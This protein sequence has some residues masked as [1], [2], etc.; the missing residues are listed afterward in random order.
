MELLQKMAT[1]IRAEIDQNGSTA[2][3]FICTENSR[4]SHISQLWAAVMAHHFNLP[5]KTFSGGTKATAINPRTVAAMQR[6][7]FDLTAGEGENPK[8]QFTFAEGAAPI[9]AFSKV[10]DAPENP[11]KDF[12]ALMVCGHA[13]A[14]CPFIPTAKQRFA[15]TFDDPKV[16]D[17]TPLEAATYDERVAEIGTQV[18]ELFRLIKND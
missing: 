9:V 16:N 2:L 10:F 6:A 17:D 3:N 14:N 13:D 4:R 15:F 1:A 12:F 8:H 7:G 18:F 11:Q 5:I